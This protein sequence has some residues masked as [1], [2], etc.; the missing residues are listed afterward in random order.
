MP[1]GKRR[2]AEEILGIQPARK[3][4]EEILG[5]APRPPV[6]EVGFLENLRIGAEQ[7]FQEYIL[8]PALSGLEALGSAMTGDFGPAKGIAEMAGRG[9]LK[10]ASAF[11]PAG[12]AYGPTAAEQDPAIAALQAQ[13]AQ[14]RQGDV[15]FG[16]V[17]RAQQE[18]AQEAARDPSLKGRITRGAAKMAVGVGPAVAAGIATGGSVPAVAATTALQSLDRPE[19]LALNVGAAVTPVPVGRVVAPILRRVRGARAGAV[20]AEQ[21]AVSKV[22]FP[23]E[24]ARRAETG[25]PELEAPTSASPRAS[26]RRVG[27]APEAD[28]DASLV[29][30]TERTPV[31]ET[32]SALRKAGLLT[33]AKTHLKNVGGNLGFQLSEEAA[34]VPAAIAD[35]LISPFTKRRTITGPSLD[36]MARSSYEAATKGVKEARDIIRRGVTDED[37]IRLGLDREINSGSKILDSYVNGVFRLLNAEDRV[38]RT[39]AYRRALEDRAKAMA[40]TEIRAGEISRGS[41]GQR[42][43]E[44]IEQPPESLASGALADAEVATF[45]E[46][47]RL[48]EGFSRFKEALPPSGRFAADLIFP[49]VK[50]PTNIVKRMLEYSPL[51]FGRN[52]FQVASAVTK[53]AFTEAEQRAFAQTFGRAAV[54]S[55]LV[56]LG[57][58][59]YSE[60]VMTGLIEDDPARRARDEAAGRIPGA[61][62]NPLTNTWHQVVGFAPLGNLL[63]IGATL[64]REVGQERE[65]APLSAITE[66]VTQAVGEQPLLIGTQQIASA[67]RSPGTTSARLLGGIA[68]SFVP[69][70][71]SDIA[72]ASDPN[73]REARTLVDRIEKRIPGVRNLLPEDVDVL[74]RPRQDFGPGQA[75]IDP[76]RAATAEQFTN[77]L[78]GELVR[79][80]QGI[81]G[82]RKK[83]DETEEIYTR[84]VQAFGQLFT[85]FGLA[86]MSS[87]QYQAATDNTRRAAF[88]SLNR[89]IKLLLGEGEEREAPQRLNAATLFESVR[90]QQSR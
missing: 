71:A 17:E 42:V 56:A 31:I 14:R 82:F 85:R 6:P 88:D 46:A 32:I 3:S 64:A 18:L 73:Q 52:A 59:L 26:G 69:T 86:L 41:L 67:L 72:E 15:L 23:E 20:G 75:F 63:A 49:F 68:G 66:V 54:G 22:N 19:N 51:G 35:M 30:A 33:G 81:S 1:Q 8:N 60:G 40:L 12:N 89:R 7:G 62:L 27:P 16:A 2:T 76:T 58:K 24:V 57:A 36:S 80:D 48:A 45:T 28:V 13:K 83:S 37:M 84:R 47:N 90:R 9:A 29:S 53:K 39:Y 44:I 79:L 25:L 38:F 55:G 21:S 43:R 78:F 77:P 74:G 87:P 50:T 11:D 61:I 4:A 34:R 5:I 70:M 65:D 10:F